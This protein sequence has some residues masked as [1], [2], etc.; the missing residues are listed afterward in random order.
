M[1]YFKFHKRREVFFSYNNQVLLGVISQ[2][3]LP[4]WILQER[5][6][7]PLQFGQEE[8]ISKHS[9]ES[10]AYWFILKIVRVFLILTSRNK[11]MNTF[12]IVNI[13]PTWCKRWLKG[14]VYACPF[15]KGLP[16]P[17]SLARNRICL[18]TNL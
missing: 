8:N 14:Y 18:G 4:F 15:K 12:I 5:P 13:N 16:F 6:S 2:C 7:F 3:G 9:I 17:F 11:I 1:D 10:R